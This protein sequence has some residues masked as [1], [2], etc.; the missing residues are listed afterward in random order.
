MSIPVTCPGCLTRFK[1][2]DKFAGKQGPCPK[3]KK[4]IQIPDKSE[5]VVVHA[6]TVGPTDTSG[7]PVLKPISREDTKLS[8][9]QI[10]LIVVIIVGFFLSALLTRM[11]IEE[12]EFP[13]WLVWLAAFAIAPPVVYGS[14]T[15]LRDQELGSF[16]GRDLW[17]RVLGCSAA[18]AL[19]WFA[20]PLAKI[21]F[22]TY[23]LGAWITAIIIM[24]AAGAAVAMLI[25]DLDYLMG[26]VHFGLYL[27]VCLLMRLI[28]GIGV[29]PGMLQQNGGGNPGEQVD[30]GALPTGI[31]ALTD[32]T[33]QL[34]AVWC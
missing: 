3:C 30:P 34:L 32:A 28:A 27:G 7:R 14:Y 8:T 31:S 29:L 20:M 24:I 2:S 4:T 19:L 23:G 11:M 26:L 9:V 13:D 16:I 17:L 12:N 22:L 5:A 25:V 1:V 18:Y 33:L 21:A 10:V 6:P 15:F